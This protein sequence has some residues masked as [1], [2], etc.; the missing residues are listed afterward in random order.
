MRTRNHVVGIVA[1]L[2]V[3]VESQIIAWSNFDRVVGLH[4]AH[5]V[6][7]HVDGI[8]VFDGRVVVA[9]TSVLAVVGGDADT[10]ECALVYAVDVDALGLLGDVLVDLRGRR[11]VT[12]MNV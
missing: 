6:A 4:I 9:A 5:N 2:M 7:A 10:F 1:L 3:P 11:G 12:Q 8:E